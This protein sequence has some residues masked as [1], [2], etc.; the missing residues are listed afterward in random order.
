MDAVRIGPLHRVGLGLA[1][2]VM[3]TASAAAQLSPIPFAT[4]VVDTPVDS[5]FVANS[6]TQPTVVFV[7][8]V[9]VPNA[10][11]VRLNFG[12]VLLAGSE[13][14]GTGSFLTIT[15][16]LDGAVQTLH[17]SHLRQWRNTSA[18]FNG[19]TVRVEL[20]AYPD[21]GPNRLVIESTRAD[22]VDAGEEAAPRSPRSLCGTEDDRELSSDP[23]SAR[24]VNDTFVGT[25]FLIDD[26]NHCFVTS[27][28]NASYLDDDAVIEFN[29]PL[30]FPN[31]TTLNHPPPEDQ[32][33]PD[34]DSVQY[35]SGATDDNWGYFGCFAN[36]TSGLTP[37]ETQG[38]F[39]ALAGVVPPATGQGLRLYGHGATFPP[40]FRT[41]SY[42]QKTELGSYALLDGTE[43][44]FVAD[45]T[46]GDSGAPL[47]DEAGGEVIGIATGD[48]CTET[49]GA[50]VG[51]AVNNLG[52]R[53]A[54][55]NPQGVCTALVF[56][57][58]N[59]LPDLLDPAGGTTLRVEVTGANGQVPAP[60]TGQLHYSDGGP[61]VTIP[62]DVILPN[63]YDAVFPPIDCGRFVDFYVSAETATGFR[64][65]D[66]LDNPTITM[67]AVAATGVAAI[68]DLDFESAPGW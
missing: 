53:A 30:S 49:G 21:T 11:C 48:G 13:Q 35:N 1:L 52:L 20:V 29:A 12:D 39:F 32:Y 51:T 45:L 60:G 38:A 15:S 27:G 47:I 41:W 62:M 54:L 23:R 50:N 66:Q 37:F 25:V 22:S 5:A 19:D 46:F 61:Y 40:V 3:A 9:S 2:F 68:V 31:G 34:L 43:I 67:R 7:D 26:A 55:A 57:Y 59:G 65:P 56:T 16:L 28:Q 33:A 10:A 6:G 58:P 24:V 14:D 8:E 42:T 4:R 17:E 63:V 18:Y 64:F 44:S 36:S